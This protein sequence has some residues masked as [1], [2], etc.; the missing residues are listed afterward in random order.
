M[1]HPRAVLAGILGVSTATVSHTVC[2]VTADLQALG[3]TVPQVPIPVRTAK[4]L[5]A[6]VDQPAS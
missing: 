1:A 4:D 5:A 6:L 3:H 2:E